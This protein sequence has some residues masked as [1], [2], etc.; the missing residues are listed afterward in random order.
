M[1]SF[2]HRCYLALRRAAEQAYPEEACGILL[3]RREGSNE[4]VER[5]IACT[6]ADPEPTRR[7]SIPP[8]ELIAA[9]REA[10][11]EQ[12]EI[13]GFYHSHPDHPAEASDTDLNEAYWTGCIYLICGVEQ[14]KLMEVSAVRLHVRKWTRVRIHFQPPDEPLEGEG[15]FS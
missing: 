2:P 9:Q 11:D 6:N 14:G 10:R 3:G 8:Q 15:F 13:L 7:Y 4:I 1:L 5:L 12:L